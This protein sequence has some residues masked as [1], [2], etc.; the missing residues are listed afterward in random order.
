MHDLSKRAVET[1]YVEAL[2]LADEARLTMQIAD[3]DRRDMSPVLRTMLSVEQLR[4]STRLMHI[5]AWLMSRRALADGEISQKE[6]DHPSRALGE[7]PASDPSVID[8]MPDDVQIM[9]HAS[10][11]LAARAEALESS[12]NSVQRLGPAR[13]LQRRLTK[14]YQE[15]NRS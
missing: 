5:V 6:A 1:L 14:K 3:A 11:E 10:I 8:Q 15:S 9:I 4:I 13:D 2:L 7:M 12:G